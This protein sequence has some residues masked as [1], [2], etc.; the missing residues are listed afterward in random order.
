VGKIET[1]I[2][3]NFASPAGEGRPTTH[4]GNTHNS[5]TA[6]VAHRQQKPLKPSLGFPKEHGRW[7]S[8]VILTSF[9]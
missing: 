4:S 9:C 8:D 6:G 2:S 5:A 1:Q 3:G 7:S